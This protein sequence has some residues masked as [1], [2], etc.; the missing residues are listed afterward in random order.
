MVLSLLEFDYVLLPRAPVSRRTATSATCAGKRQPRPAAQQVEVEPAAEVRRGQRRARPR[1]SPGRSR[2]RQA[3]P[4]G[5]RR[6][7]RRRCARPP[8]CA[9]GVTRPAPRAVGRPSS[10][11]QA[12]CR[13]WVH[14]QKT[15]SSAGVRPGDSPRPRASR[16]RSSSTSGA[17]ERAG[18]QPRL[19]RR[20]RRPR[21]RG[22]RAPGRAPR[23][24]AD[25]QRAHPGRG[26]AGPQALL[27]LVGQP[28]VAQRVGAPGA[29]VLDEQEGPDRARRCRPAARRGRGRPRRSGTR[30]PDDFEEPLA[31][32]AAAEHQPALLV[33]VQVGRAGSVGGADGIQS[34]ARASAGTSSSRSPS[35]TRTFSPSGRSTHGWPARRRSGGGVGEV[36]G[37]DPVLETAALPERAAGEE[38]A[39]LGVG[40]GRGVQAA[41]R[42]GQRLQPLGQAVG[43][44]R[45]VVEVAGRQVLGTGVV[46]DVRPGRGRGRPSRPPG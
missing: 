44:Q 38:A 31:H 9:R 41:Q 21:T 27:D 22:C 28:R 7:G 35:S 13:P 8:R 5:W 39:H 15:G 3:A 20:R 42:G 45:R 19:V 18:L 16:S 11:Q 43:E 36:A 23:V 10:A 32:E 1:G 17:G 24:P 40:D 30:S 2:G 34:R 12:S 4:A 26:R 29:G 25:Q 33:E 14:T 6:T 46:E 37:R